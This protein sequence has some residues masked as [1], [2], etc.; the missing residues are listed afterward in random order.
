LSEI[1]GTTNWQ[2]NFMGTFDGDGHTIEMQFQYQSSEGSHA[3]FG[4]FRGPQSA[5]FK[6]LTITGKISA[7]SNS[8][9]TTGTNHVGGFVGRAHGSLTFENCT[10][11]VD[12]ISRGFSVGGFIGSTKLTTGD[13]VNYTFTG[14]VNTGDI[15]TYYPVGQITYEQRSNRDSEKYGVGGFIGTVWNGT[16]NITYNNP[17]DA[18]WF[19][20]SGDG[21]PIYGISGTFGSAPVVTMDSCRNAG[22]IYGS[23]NVGGLIGYNGGST[24]VMNCGNTGN[25]TAIGEGSYSYNSSNGSVSVTPSR[26]SRSYIITTS[27]NKL[28][29]YVR[30]YL[31]AGGLV[32][33]STTAGH[34][35]MY[36]SYNSGRVHAYGNT[37]GGLIGSDTEYTKTRQSSKTTKIYYCYNAGEVITGLDKYTVFLGSNNDY[38]D[39][40][41]ANNGDNYLDDKRFMKDMG[42]SWVGV[43]DQD[44]RNQKTDHYEMSLRHETNVE[45]GKRR[46]G[47]SFGTT[48][49]GIIGSTTNTNIKYCYNIGTIICRGLAIYTHGS[50][51]SGISY[52][53]F[54]ARAGGIVGLVD[55]G[56]VSVNN[57]Y[58]VG[59]IKLE[60]RHAT[61]GTFGAEN[62]SGIGLDFGLLKEFRQT[63]PMYVAGIVGHDNA[64]TN[65]DVNNCFS[66][67]Y[68]C[69]FL[70]EYNK[71]FRYHIEGYNDIV[72][73]VIKNKDT[74]EWYGLRELASNISSG[75]VKNAKIEIGT[76]LNSEDENSSSGQV[77][78]SVAQLTAIMNADGVVTMPG[79]E[80]YT[81]AD[82]TQLNTSATITHYVSSATKLNPDYANGQSDV[83]IVRDGMSAVKAGLVGG[84]IFM[85]GCL[86]QL[87][88]FALDTQDGLAMT[89]YGYGRNTQGEFVKQIA[90][91]E[92]NPYIIKDGIDLL[93][94]STLVAGA[95]TSGKLV[96]SI[97]FDGKYIEFANG[98]NNLAGDV[99]EAIQ[100]PNKAANYNTTGN[101]R[102]YIFYD[103]SKTQGEQKEGKSYQLYNRAA[104]GLH[105][106][107]GSSNQT[108]QTRSHPA[109]SLRATAQDTTD[110]KFNTDKL[111]SAYTMWTRM[112]HGFNGTS[113]V[114]GVMFDKHNINPIGYRGVTSNGT[115]F[116]FMGNISGA[117]PGEKQTQII[118][119]RV[120][121]GYT[122]TE[123]GEKNV[124]A[125]LF[126]LVKNA[127]ISNITAMGDVIAYGGTSAI[128]HAGLV[129]KAY[130][131]TTLTGLSAGTKDNALIVK[132]GNGKAGR[133]GGIIGTADSGATGNRFTVKD[134]V[135]KKAVVSTHNVELTLDNIFNIGTG[136]IIGFTQGDDA[137]SFTD[138]LGCHVE[139]ADIKSSN[140]FAVAGVIG[141][142]GRNGA[143]AVS[144]C[145][146]GNAPDA[147]GNRAQFSENNGEVTSGVK[148]EGN[149]AMGGII[150]YAMASSTCTNS[151]INC[152]VYDDV[153]IKRTT[154]SN[155]GTYG[156]AIGGI[157]GGILDDESGKATFSG[158]ICF[159]GTI[160]LSANTDNV[161]VGGVVGYMGTSARMEQCVVEI[162][163]TI[164]T[165][166]TGDGENIGGF[167]GIS[168][169]VVLD[170]VFL[171][172]PTMNVTVCDAV[173]GFIGYNAGDT[174]IARSAIVYTTPAEWV[175]SNGD[176][177]A[178]KEEII[179][180]LSQVGNIVAN[181]DVG[182][183]IG[184][185]E[186]GKKIVLGVE[187]YKGTNYGEEGD[188]TKIVLGSSVDGN[189]H[190]GGFI[191]HNAGVIDGRACEID[192]SGHVGAASK[193]ADDG[194]QVPLCPNSQYIGGV[195]GFIE[196]GGSI[197][198]GYDATIIN[199]GQVGSEQFQVA[200]QSFV[201]GIIGASFGTITVEGTLANMG[202]VY[203]Y[204]YVGGAIGVVGEGTISGRLDNGSDV[205][206]QALGSSYDGS[207]AL[208]A[209]EEL[210][211]TVSSVTAVRNVGGV[212]GVVMQSAI[213]DGAQMTNYGT[214]T[215]DSIK[216]IEQNGTMIPSMVDGVIQS[217]IDGDKKFVSNLGGVIGLH[218]GVIK[219][220]SAFK[221]YGNITAENFAG[222]AIGVSDGTIEQ[223]E[224][225]NHATI[226][227]YGNT[228]LGGS[229]GYIT[230]GYTTYY[231]NVDGYQYVAGKTTQS[232]V[233]HIS[234]MNL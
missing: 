234:V 67:K 33:L 71:Y 41:D 206:V 38:T 174:H 157:A 86:P 112:H 5:T 24:E 73:G 54:H 214:V 89:S 2:N 138:V 117:L 66:I 200:N 4:L 162:G 51:Y 147:N 69:H 104:N 70:N 80:S 194:K 215:A 50:G 140:G 105:G 230:K 167:A 166:T 191:G 187:E 217:I 222:G 61:T 83:R 152:F 74:G 164:T 119:L 201:G 159:Y 132:T 130:G 205:E 224:F 177:V 139:K 188:R 10:N 173:G 87:A 182:G 99:C 103:N 148:I 156:S 158:Y 160:D 46:E 225:I 59:D 21:E 232:S 210:A 165:G 204:E 142:Q 128:A 122:V 49:G 47:G 199:D 185:N 146:V 31:N 95:N 60:A 133:A 85:P 17:I 127:N 202:S 35:D 77:V 136:G 113:Y 26:D 52:S 221:N 124:Y 197:T 106:V 56:S 228:A 181:D 93:G 151:Y 30:R 123:G 170:G 207:E 111:D 220:S 116:A 141:N 233:I 149:V 58:S 84:W 65:V 36:T 231:P 229:V 154:G 28:S 57:S 62:W 212:I 183:F 97:N 76:A 88:P 193:R 143:V 208:V 126:G 20:T 161:N 90:G 81:Q 11:D 102:D 53:E 34:V 196:H 72:T 135:V 42:D 226:T 12:I 39:R 48:V 9:G 195:V 79:G 176:G 23:Y 198:I 14:C 45:G 44:H 209:A 150:A 189:G 172:H 19:G 219:G 98:S 63:R 110:G 180:T 40:Y 223:A 155:V 184:H 15:V 107:K 145:I 27:D 92:F 175:D 192:N 75:K 114:A 6:N 169:G 121:G 134:S 153:Y 29:V 179:P 203:G 94:L 101:V 37:A 178:A 78:S 25:V 144:D 7:H 22:N 64:N 137:S 125:G 55:S 100:L 115:N 43:D 129:A 168:K 109:T 91:S 213:I 108:S 16:M 120:S 190:V 13:Q 131:S 218:Y 3:E 82:K 68:Q 163:G 18:G 227:F 186:A 171:V 211:G 32:G 1:V 96:A 216:Y 118:N 8:T